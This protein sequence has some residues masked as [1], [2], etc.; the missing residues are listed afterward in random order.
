MKDLQQTTHSSAISKVESADPMVVMS[1]L[2][3]T[4]VTC[5]VGC[6]DFAEMSSVD[7]KQFVQTT[8][9]E[10]ADHYDAL[11]RKSSYIYAALCEV[12]RRF[13]KRP[14]ARNDIHELHVN[15]WED[16]LSEC[17]VKPAT[18]RKWRQR[19]NNAIRR[20]EAMANPGINPGAS[21]RP[22]GPVR[23]DVHR[24]SAVFDLE[25]GR[26]CARICDTSRL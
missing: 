26:H 2:K 16:F 20:L 12:E 15:G 21:R 17:G 10:C 23:P 9:V 4:S 22:G 6:P 11:G 1:S 3:G 14:G 8:M 18:F 19:A 25:S 5:H 13:G 24:T 7:I